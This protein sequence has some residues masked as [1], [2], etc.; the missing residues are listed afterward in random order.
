MSGVA[1]DLTEDVVA[2]RDG[3]LRFVEA[4]VAP[5]IERHRAVLEDQRR[6]YGDDGRY[7]P[8]IRALIRDIR[9]LSA[10][11][12]FYAMCA[13]TEL[14]GGGLG[15]LVYYV[16][17]E[18]I[19]RRLGSQGVVIPWVIAHWAFGPSRLLTQVTDEAR[20]RCLAGMMSGETSMC[21]GLSEPGAGSDA[22]MIQTRAVKSG[23]GWRI[24]GRKLWTSNAP[25]A[26]WCIVFAITDAGKAARKAGGISAFLVPTD[27]SG[28]SVESVVRLFGHAGGH[29]GALVL[30]DVE[31]QPWQLVGQL[32][33]GFK[34]ALYGVSLGRVYNSARA[35][36]QG[37]WALEM[38]LDYAKQRQAFGAP[39]ADY[40]GVSFPLAQCATELH[41]A[42]LMGLNAAMLLDRGDKAVKE[43]SMAKAYAVQAGFRAVDRA[44]QTHGGMGLTNEVG[45]VHAW[46]DL[47]IV[48]IA[49]G[50]NEIL[51]RTIAQRLLTGD[52]EL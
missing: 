7:A 2:V 46:H 32:D 31:V 26:E 44:M 36:G 38:A 12:G 5:R 22:S 21:F 10:E 34:I 1:F 35:V 11:A 6:L 49:D 8:E 48:N 37:R 40:Q 30:D 52:V 29:E 39:I 45:L 25:T 27:A 28:F 42:H 50:T 41:A 23:R 17:W 16:A 3:V 47:R 51:T 18:A 13:P 15:H 4:Q 24:A 43:L 9:M 14:G 33:E 20:R 19:Y